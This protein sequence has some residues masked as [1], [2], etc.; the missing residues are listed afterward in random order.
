[1][2]RMDREG[3]KWENA[4][5]LSLL[6]TFEG[7]ER[8]YH[9]DFM[10]PEGLVEIKPSTLHSAP[11]IVAKQAVAT[12]FCAEND[13]TYRLL[14][15]PIDKDALNQAYQN[16]DLLF[17]GDYEAKFLAYPTHRACTG[18]TLLPVPRTT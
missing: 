6:Y 11:L 18:G 15:E 2:M 3:I 17:G 1:M 12:V 8:T 5:H 7:K 4:E 10:T 16:G 13:M 14:D 9:P